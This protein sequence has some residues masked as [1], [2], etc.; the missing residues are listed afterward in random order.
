MCAERSG[1]SPVGRQG[2]LSLIELVMF[3]VIVSVGI[4]GILAV[5]NVAVKS[6]A[7]PMLHKQSLAIAEALMDEIMAKAYSDPDGTSGETDRALMDDVSDYAYF[8]GADAAHTI[9]GDQTLAATS[10]PAL[11]AY[12]A[13]VAVVGATLSSIAAKQVTVTVTAPNGESLALSG[14]R[15]DR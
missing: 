4:A 13:Q 7:D 2:G 14:Y 8:N 10:V 3:I 5:F 11:S 12:R 1:S 6:S 15:T 9:T